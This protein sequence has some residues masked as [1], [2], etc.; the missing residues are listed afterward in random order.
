MKKS[1][2]KLKIVKVDWVDAAASVGWQDSVYEGDGL[3]YCTSVGFPVHE[4][5]N[6]IVLAGTYSDGSHNNRI[7]IPK[8]WI[9]NKQ[10]WQI[11][12]HLPGTS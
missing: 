10:E 2:T 7:A 11:K 8:A 5:K 9:R 6:Q 12:E 3:A 4:D 1:V